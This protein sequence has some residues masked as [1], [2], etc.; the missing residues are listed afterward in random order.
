[1]GS[2][3]RKPLIRLF[4]HECTSSETDKRGSPCPVPSATSLS[5][6]T[7]QADLLKTRGKKQKK[8]RKLTRS[9]E[10]NNFG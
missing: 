2:I 6:R 3:S 5:K 9:G 4:V 10:S 7:T 8:A 1:M